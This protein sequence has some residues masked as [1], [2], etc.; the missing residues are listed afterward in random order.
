MCQTHLHLLV[1][2]LGVDDFGKG[3]NIEN[4]MP[5]VCEQ[6]EKEPVWISLHLIALECEVGGDESGH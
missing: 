2:F 5:W 6:V 1:F 3:L 4:T